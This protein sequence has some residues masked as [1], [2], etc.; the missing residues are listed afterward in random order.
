MKD[1]LLFIV[2]KIVDHPEDVAIDE[3][4]DNERTLFVIHTNPEDIG[5]VIGK[6]GRIIRAIRDVI[7]MIAAKHDQYVDVSIYEEPA[8]A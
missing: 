4:T 8:A 2:Q 5:K 1:T 6:Q 3:Q 7:K